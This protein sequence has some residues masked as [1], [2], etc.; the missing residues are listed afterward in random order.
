MSAEIKNW[1]MMDCLVECV[2]MAVDN[3]C[4]VV[5]LHY[6][7]NILRNAAFTIETAYGYVNLFRI[8]YNEDICP[9]QKILLATITLNSGLSVSSIAHIFQMLIYKEL[10]TI[11][12]K[13]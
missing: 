6:F 5:K 9:E 12:R 2:E 8:N 13:D 11:K 3:S 7:D 10:K 1:E 4:K